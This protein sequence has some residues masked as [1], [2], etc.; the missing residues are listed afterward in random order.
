MHL[1]RHSCSAAG[2]HDI[3]YKHFARGGEDSTGSIC[4]G[5]GAQRQPQWQPPLS[6]CWWRPWIVVLV[7]V[8]VIVLLVL[9][10]LDAPDHELPVPLDGSRTSLHYDNV[11]NAGTS[12]T[13]TRQVELLS[14]HIYLEQ[15][16]LVRQVLDL[17][18]QDL[19]RRLALCE[20]LLLLLRL[21]L[22]GRELPCLVA[23][24]VLLAP[25]LH[26]RPHLALDRGGVG[27]G[28]VSKNAHQVGHL[29]LRG[30]RLQDTHL[31]LVAD[32]L[33]PLLPLQAPELLSLL[34]S[35]VHHGCL[36]N[37]FLGGDL[38]RDRV[39][40]IRS[41]LLYIDLGICP[42]L[43]IHVLLEERHIPPLD[44]RD[45][46]TP[47]DLGLDLADADVR[48]LLLLFFVLLFLF[49]LALLLLVLLLIDA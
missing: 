11:R 12:D 27:D 26:L 14:V 42:L 43:A 48:L 9:S 28:L 34:R 35:Q 49:L 31:D 5:G 30:R 6:R 2:V 16:P 29:D 15:V 24:L 8:V 3:T 18:G 22:F 46:L 44:V 36:R 25:L 41:D 10:P 7:V 37:L 33:R 23:L 40:D 32:F 20:P 39:L 38:D 21:S 4:V 19:R 1:C 47:Q 13:A 17:K 45:W